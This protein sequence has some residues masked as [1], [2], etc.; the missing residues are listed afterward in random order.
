MWFGVPAQTRRWVLAAPGWSR[1]LPNQSDEAAHKPKK[2]FKKLPDLVHGDLSPHGSHSLPLIPRPNSFQKPRISCLKGRSSTIDDK[3]CN[4]ITDRYSDI[5]PGIPKW[6]LVISG[7]SYWLTSGQQKGMGILALVEVTDSDCRKEIR[8]ILVTAQKAVP[9]NF[10]WPCRLP[11]VPQV[12][13][14]S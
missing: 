12:Q 10:R 14:K 1:G 5:H 8:L 13:S 6:N 11:P 9:W 4:D 3:P 2:W 7:F